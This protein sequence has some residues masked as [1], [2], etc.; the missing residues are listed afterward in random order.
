MLKKIV[1]LF[2]LL[3]SFI[4]YSDCLN[5]LNHDVRILA[6]SETRNLCD[7]KDK[8]ILAV[9]VASQCGYTYQYE[10]LQSLYTKYKKE[11]FVVL[12]F[13]SNDF[14][15]ERAKDEE[16]VKEFCKTT[17]GV[18]FPMFK[19]SHVKTGGGVIRKSFKPNPFYEDLIK[20]TGIEPAWNFNK[21]LISKEGN[22]LHFNQDVEP[23]SKQLLTIISSLL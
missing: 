11:D 2:T 3:V 7:F 5:I 1:L 23:D 19:R 15:Q 9:N 10:S 6:S 13:P 4:S 21:Y 16:E 8:V 12:G 20:K 18:D 22:V 14:F 17:Y